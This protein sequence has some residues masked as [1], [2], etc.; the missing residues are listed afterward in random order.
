MPVRLGH[1]LIKVLPL[2]SVVL[3]DFGKAVSQIIAIEREVKLLLIG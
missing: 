3:N 1:Q 2:L